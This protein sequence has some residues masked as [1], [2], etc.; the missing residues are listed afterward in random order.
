MSF[1]TDENNRFRGRGDF[2]IVFRPESI[3]SFSA[4]RLFPSPR[5]HYFLGPES[6]ALRDSSLKTAR[7][8]A[9]KESMMALFCYCYEQSARKHFRWWHNWAT[10]SRL[11]PMI[12]KA[13]MIKRRF[14]KYRYLP[15]AP[16][17]QR[18]QRVSQLKDSMG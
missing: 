17:H 10:R 1:R 5:N 18:R 15:Q 8:W 4:E 16:R 3:I 6:A 9:L 14:E 2:S 13:R 12:E 7:A 11:Q